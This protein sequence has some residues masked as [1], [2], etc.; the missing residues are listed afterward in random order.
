[1]MPKPP[2]RPE[3][4]LPLSPPYP[5]M[6]ALRREKIPQGGGGWQAEPCSAPGD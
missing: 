1:M 6:E 3:L 2:E 4:E 5:P